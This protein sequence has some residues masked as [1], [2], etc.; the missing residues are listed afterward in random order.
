MLINVFSCI[1]KQTIIMFLKTCLYGNVSS[2]S[3][4]GSAL[5]RRFSQFWVCFSER[6]L[7]RDLTQ[8]CLR[9]QNWQATKRYHSCSGKCHG[10]STQCVCSHLNSPHSKDLLQTLFTDEMF[11][12]PKSSPSPR[13]G[14]HGPWTKIYFGKMFLRFCA[15][16]IVLLFRS[17]ICISYYTSHISHHWEFMNKL[18][19]HE[20][21]IFGGFFPIKCWR[22][23]H[24]T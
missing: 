4:C 16:T 19:F 11:C 2:K 18:D 5:P 23:I 3:Q 22:N 13:N 21:S 1:W 15:K 7:H 6:L 12:C 14:V 17:R 8:K 9:K 20:K 10:W 24:L